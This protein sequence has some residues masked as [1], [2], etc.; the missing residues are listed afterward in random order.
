[1]ANERTLDEIQN[2]IRTHG[3]WKFRLKSAITSGKSDVTPEA[4]GCDDACEFGKWLHN[5]SM[6]AEIKNGTPHKVVTRLHAE[7][8]QTAAS[9][10]KTALSGDTTR[11]KGLLDG[12]FKQQSDKLVSALTLW[13]SELRNR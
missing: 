13:K 3:M 10:L 5:G 2:A 8:H 11:A 9:V 1:M 7:F 6:P 4:A 12:V